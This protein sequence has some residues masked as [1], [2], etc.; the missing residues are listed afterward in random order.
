MPQ[1]MSPSHSIVIKHL[2]C[3]AVSFVLNGHISMEMRDRDHCQFYARRDSAAMFCIR[4]DKYINNVVQLSKIS[5]S[6]VQRSSR[7]LTP[8]LLSDGIIW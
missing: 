3:T 1:M 7:G 8:P 2:K 4:L 6:H 5:K